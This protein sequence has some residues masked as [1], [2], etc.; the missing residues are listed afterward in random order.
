MQNTIT[1]EDKNGNEVESV[2]FTE[3]LDLSGFVIREMLATKND[4]MRFQAGIYVSTPMKLPVYRG[5]MVSHH[6][7]GDSIQRFQLHG[8]A[9]TKQEALETASDKLLRRDIE[10]SKLKKRKKE[11]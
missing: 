11:A 6:K 5:S 10:N 1:K 4:A 8:N 3:Y 9:S 2:I 7:D